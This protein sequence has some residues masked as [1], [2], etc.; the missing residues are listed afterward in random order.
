MIILLEINW[1]LV[2]QWSLPGI[3]ASTGTTDSD[4]AR[5]DTNQVILCVCVC[6][7]LRVCW[8]IKN[9]KSN[10]GFS[11]FIAPWYKET[12]KTWFFE[13]RDFL[14][15]GMTASK[16]L[17]PL[18]EWKKNYR[19]Y[20]IQINRFNPTVSIQKLV[21]KNNNTVAVSGHPDPTYCPS[22]P[23]GGI[24]K[25]NR[26]E[27]LRSALRSCFVNVMVTIHVHTNSRSRCKINIYLVWLF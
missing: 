18:Y 9:T 15:W 6:V 7:R 11:Y 14:A 4:T 22:V 17:W 23:G 8:K 3:Q 1:N 19:V 26:I 25:H 5:E 24:E 2:V 10:Y 13:F 21:L 12:E 16:F 27:H 20:G